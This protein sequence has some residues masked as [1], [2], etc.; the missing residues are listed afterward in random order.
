MSLHGNLLQQVHRGRW[1][2]SASTGGPNYGKSLLSQNRLSGERLWRGVSQQ[3]DTRTH[4]ALPQM[5]SREKLLRLL[6]SRG[7]SVSFG[8]RS[9]DPGSM[10]DGGD[11]GPIPLNP[12]GA[13]P[14]TPKTT[15]SYLPRRKTSKTLSQKGRSGF[16]GLY[17]ARVMLQAK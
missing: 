13:S 17:A 12:T 2:Q 6:R 8:L 15:L 16:E 4:C 3:N 7:N 10:S 1:N 11:N 14:D 5:L 9:F